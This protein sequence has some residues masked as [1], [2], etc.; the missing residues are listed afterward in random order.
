MN[1]EEDM[2]GWAG[3]WYE[4]SAQQ[5]LIC[6]PKLAGSLQTEASSHTSLVFPKAPRYQ[7]HLLDNLITSIDTLWYLDLV[8][9]L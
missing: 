2:R 8:K 5:M 7:G 1:R 4:A 9:N 3:L 6:V